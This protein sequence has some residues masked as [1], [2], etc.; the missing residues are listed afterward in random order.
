MFASYPLAAVVEATPMVVRAEVA[1]RPALSDV[2]ASGRR[3][4][5]T[6]RRAGRAFRR[7]RAPRSTEESGGVCHGAGVTEEQLVG[8]SANVGKVGWLP[9]HGWHRVW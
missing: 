1:R 5:L 9:P 3:T 2:P 4:S 7:G 8:V 6:D